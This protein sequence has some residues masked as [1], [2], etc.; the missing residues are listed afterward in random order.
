MCLFVAKAL[1]LIHKAASTDLRA[2]SLPTGT[3]LTSAAL[4][5]PRSIRTVV[6]LSS[7]SESAFHIRNITQSLTWGKIGSST[8]KQSTREHRTGHRLII[9]STHHRE[10]CLGELSYLLWCQGHSAVG[11][12]R[13]RG[14]KSF[15]LFLF[16]PR[17]RGTGSSLSSLDTLGGTHSLTE[18]SL[19][20]PLQG[21]CWP[22]LTN[23]LVLTFVPG[24]KVSHFRNL[25]WPL[26]TT[27]CPVA[28]TSCR[29]ASFLCPTN[30]ASEMNPCRLSNQV[31]FF[32]YSGR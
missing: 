21:V 3:V 7:L 16:E 13:Y 10:S 2:T 4:I 26:I 15:L 31:F 11:S 27:L 30:C 12:P 9:R 17:D 24:T 23:R 22:L 18:A 5:G 29:N 1:I 32:I 8:T 20:D 28:T 19:K 6:L 14:E 25:P